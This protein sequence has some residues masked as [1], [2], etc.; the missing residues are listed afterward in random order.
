MKNLGEFIG[1]FTVEDEYNNKKFI[2]YFYEN[3]ITF[4]DKFLK[5]ILEK[6]ELSQELLEIN[7][8]WKNKSKNKE[9]I[10]NS[11]MEV[12]NNYELDFFNFSKGEIDK[13][14]LYYSFL[15]E[16]DLL[17]RITR[18]EFENKILSEKV[19]EFYTDVLRDTKENSEFYTYT[20]EVSGI[21]FYLMVVDDKIKI[22]FPE[23]ITN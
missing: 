20:S 17:T 2:V 5:F 10:I 22:G 9:E 7:N 23:E 3:G 18:K 14:A 6:E 19:G 13:N 21:D 15:K 1:N 11:I 8:S 12:F 16:K 4:D